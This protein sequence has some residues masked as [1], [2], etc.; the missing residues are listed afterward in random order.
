M[1][2]KPTRWFQ[3]S[4]SFRYNTE[5]TAQVEISKQGSQF[6]G[7]IIWL[8]EPNPNGK[9][10]TDLEN[11]DP[12]LRTR[13]LMGMA[14]LKDEDVD[15]LERAEEFFKQYQ[16]EKTKPSGIQLVTLAVSGEFEENTPVYF[17]PVFQVIRDNISLVLPAYLSTHKFA[18]N[19]SAENVQLKIEVRQLFNG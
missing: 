19:K 15:V 5:K 17:H 12:K 1:K 14:I 9:P 16:I 8:Q 10:A 4:G 13:P 11:S 7:K 18:V 6:V 3:L 2:P